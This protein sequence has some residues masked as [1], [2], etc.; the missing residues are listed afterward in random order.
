MR[1]GALVSLGLAFIVMLCGSCAAP[2]PE[3]SSPVSELRERIRAR[4][5]GDLSP[6]PIPV[7]NPQTP[8]KVALGEALFFDPNLSSNPAVLNRRTPAVQRQ[9]FREERRAFLRTGLISA[10]SETFAS[11]R[12]IRANRIPFSWNI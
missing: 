6:P 12:R 11:P 5:P 3:P 9:R 7:D 1:R 4:F 10:A 2:G 8:E